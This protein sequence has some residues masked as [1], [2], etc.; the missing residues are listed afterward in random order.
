MKV[1][2]KILSIPPYISTSWKNVVSLHLE[3]R[4]GIQVLVI[5]LV[6]GAKIEVP[7]LDRPLLQA[8]FQAHE[9]YMEQEATKNSQMSPFASMG[10]PEEMTAMIALPP[11]NLGFDG[12]MG[13]LL[14]HNPEAADSPDLPREVLEK[15]GTLSKVV[16]FENVENFPKPEP[17]CNCMHCQIMRVIQNK[18]AEDSLIEIENEEDVSADDLKFR[19]WDIDQI[20]EQ[21]YVVTNPFNQSEHFNVFL[22]NPVGCTCGD[23]N[24]E[25]IRAVL[26]S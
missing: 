4:E 25:H 17:H 12:S 19:E 6:N 7:N 10:T 9:K 16:G 13:N 11:L 20:G 26:N 15:I 8:V 21:L 23:P 1:N 14:Q 2:Q 18:E 5:G 24:C 22:G 3:E